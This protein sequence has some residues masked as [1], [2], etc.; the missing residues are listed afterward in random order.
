MILIVISFLAYHLVTKTLRPDL[1]AFAFLSAVYGVAL[2]VSL[3]LAAVPATG[4]GMGG[5]MG[6]GAGGG[7]AA[8]GLPGWRD[9]APVVLLGLALVG[10]EAGFIL[11]Y[12]AG[13]PVSLAPT[14][15]NAAVAV[16]L[17]PVA[18]LLFREKVSA[19][20]LAGLGLAIAGLMLMTQRS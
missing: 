16:L 1:S 18:L 15:A 12:R 7:V 17:L 4:G 19:V 10:I 20:N 8:A 3:V 6:G 2:A 5:G 13:W 11:A 14:V 9:L